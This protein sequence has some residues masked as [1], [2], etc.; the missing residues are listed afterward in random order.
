MINRLAMV[1]QDQFE[2]FLV[3]CNRAAQQNPVMR[4]KDN[5]LN[6]VRHRTGQDPFG[7]CTGYGCGAAFNFVALLADGEVHACRDCRLWPVCRGGPAVTRSQGL[8][9]F[10]PKDPFCFWHGGNE[11]QRAKNNPHRSRITVE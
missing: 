2:P 4:L 10:E 6:I 11:R 5:L 7:G 3:A 9:V 1:P 8:N